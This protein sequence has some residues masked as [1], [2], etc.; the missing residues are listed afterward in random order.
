VK[1]VFLILIDLDL[2]G[3]APDRYSRLVL[4]LELTEPQMYFKRVGGADRMAAEI[5]ALT[6]ARDRIGTPQVM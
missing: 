1:V 4:A 5:C 6:F 3:V 2:A